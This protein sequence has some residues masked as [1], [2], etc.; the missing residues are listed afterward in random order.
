MKARHS[1]LLA[2]WYKKWWGQGLLV[3][4]ALLLVFLIVSASYVA[5]QVQA[6]LSGRA[7]VMDATQRQA[8]LQAIN[9]DGTNYY[10]GTSSPEV[11]IVEFGDF[12]CPYCYKSYTVMNQLVQKY[13]DKIKLVWRDYLRNKD[14]IDLAMTGRCAGE[15]G[16]FWPMHN[17]L[18]ADQANLTTADNSRP[19]KLVALAQ[20]LGLNITQFTACLSSE[21][22]LNQIKKDYDDGNSLNIVGTPTWFVNNY[23][24][25]GYVPLDKFSALVEGLIK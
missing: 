14:S 23:Q 3:L 10:E 15:Q 25:A 2:P 18:F 11:T 21:K 16:Q 12:A 5:A 19:A 8:Y 13:P 24:F 22:Y 9:G 7:I 17:A 6:I 4:G 20:N 1:Q